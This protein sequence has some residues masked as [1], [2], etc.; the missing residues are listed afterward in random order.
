MTLF[1]H[2]SS[3]IDHVKSNIRL[4]LFPCSI[5]RHYEIYSRFDYYKK[6]GQIYKDAFSFTQ[7]DYNICERTLYRII[8]QMEGE[9]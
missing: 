4:G 2:I 9:I 8:N 6:S 7:Y 3:N 5:L 1:Q